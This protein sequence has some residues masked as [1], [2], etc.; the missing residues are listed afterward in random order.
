MM[1]KWMLRTVTYEDLEQTR[2]VQDEGIVFAYKAETKQRLTEKKQAADL[3]VIR[4][5][6][7]AEVSGLSARSAIYSINLNA[8]F[9][10]ILNLH[11]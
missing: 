11:V 5:S 1:Q 2:F 3:L 7:A 8:L 6:V 9:L 10:Y 4:D